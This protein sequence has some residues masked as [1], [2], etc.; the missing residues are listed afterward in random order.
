MDERLVA[1]ARAVKSRGRCVGAGGMPVAGRHSGPGACL[2]GRGCVPPLW[3]FTDGARMADLVGVVK[4]LPK[5]L[6]GVVF[7]HDGA[8]GRAELA[9]EVWRLCRD[10][11]L[12]MVVAGDAVGVAG[13]GVHLRAGRVSGLRGR[14][15]FA[16]AS[17]HAGHELVRARR[18][19]VGAVFL[20]PAFQT[21]SHPGERAL[22]AVR[23]AAVAA[24]G[25]G[26]PVLALG[27]IDGASVRRLPRWVRG[28]GAVGALAGD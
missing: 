10:R 2:E 13:P 21:A 27:G 8:P 23:W 15:G 3:L 26:V 17:A 5:G 9:R 4:R 22:G 18:R 14:R 1:W 12:W 25:G 28:I 6:C 16:T 20:S 24:L 19:S 7:R 11:R